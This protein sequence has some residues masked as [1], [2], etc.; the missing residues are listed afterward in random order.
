M[1]RLTFITGYYGSGKT[2]LAVNLAVKYHVDYI[3]DLCHDR[4][5]EIKPST[6]IKLKVNGE[7]S[8]IRK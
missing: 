7:F 6:I 3:V 4:I 8:V 1:K 2:E 5:K